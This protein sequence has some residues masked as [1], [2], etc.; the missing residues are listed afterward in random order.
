M[1]TIP[2]PKNFSLPTDAAG[3]Q[4][5]KSLIDFVGK[6]LPDWARA[7]YAVRHLESKKGNVKAQVDGLGTVVVGEE[8]WKVV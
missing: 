8:G 3:Q 4:R 6:P 7:R 2:V 1:G 5:E